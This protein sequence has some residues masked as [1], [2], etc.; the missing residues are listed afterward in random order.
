MLCYLFLFIFT[1]EAL[2]HRGH[3]TQSSALHIR[4]FAARICRGYLPREFA[5]AICR[6]NLPWVFAICI[7]KKI[8]LFICEQT[9]FIWEQSFFIYE[10]NFFICEIFF[11]N[12]VSFCYCRGSYGP[13]YLKYLFSPEL[14]DKKIFMTWCN[15]FLSFLKQYFGSIRRITTEE[16]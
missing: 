12:S 4:E 11:I 8:L 6:G 7:C 1:C 3:S 16:K 9:L 13:P 15:S 5:A 14:V 2:P 10:Q